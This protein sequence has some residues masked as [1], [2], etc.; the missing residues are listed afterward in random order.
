[1]HNKYLIDL[2]RIID[3]AATRQRVHRNELIKRL[4][5]YFKEN[6]PHI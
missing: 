2:A 1:M 3:D 5:L 4:I 6:L